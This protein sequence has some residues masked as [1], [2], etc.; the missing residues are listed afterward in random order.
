MT[1]APRVNGSEAVTVPA[2]LKRY[3]TWVPA[4]NDSD[5][6]GLNSWPGQELTA[7]LTARRMDGSRAY[8]AA[9]G[10]PVWL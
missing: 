10:Q 9:P 2:E 4:E 7:A 5:L 6:G 3:P 1:A 8:S